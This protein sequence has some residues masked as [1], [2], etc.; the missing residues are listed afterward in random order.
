MDID[1]LIRISNIPLTNEDLEHTIGVKPEDILLYKNL[2][3]YKDIDELLPNNGDFKM[4]LLEWEKNKGHWVI[5]YKLNNKYYY[6]NSYGN[7]YDNDLNVL[8]MCVKKILGE[9]TKQIT[10]LL[11]G[12][13]CDWSKKR[14]QKGDAQTCGRHCVMRISMLKMGYTQTEYDKYLEDL[15]EKYEL[16]YDLIVCMFITCGNAKPI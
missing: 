10:R 1:E 13:S 2:G 3:N 11:N 15:K 14:F 7:K 12:K 5:I 9:D 4:I 16:P 8:S 6:F